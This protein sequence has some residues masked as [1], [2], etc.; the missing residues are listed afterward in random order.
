MLELN[1]FVLDDAAMR[2]RQEYYSRPEVLIEMAKC[3]KGKETVFLSPEVRVRVIKA[4][5]SGYLKMNMNKFQFMKKPVNVYHSLANLREM[6][7]FSFNLKKRIIEQNQFNKDF[8]NYYTGF[9][10]GLDF[11]AHYYDE[12]EKKLKLR[13]L[14]LVYVE[15]K[16]VKEELD[17]YKVPYILKS[18]GS[19]FHINILDEFLPKFGD[20]AIFCNKFI[21]RL[22]D[23]FNLTCL[24]DSLLDS[25]KIWKCPYSY[26]YKSGNIALP[27]DDKEFYNFSYDYIDAKNVLEN[28]KIENRGLSMREGSANGLSKFLIEYLG[29]DLYD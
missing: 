8:K 21:N 11:D 23:V 14:T 19:G 24:C 7:I 22:R 17:R 29:G 18:S 13:D 20:K 16:I 9:D 25:R 27:L 28:I 12:K 6:P 5:H 4:H 26:D 10:L 2:L 1:K 3:L 15:T